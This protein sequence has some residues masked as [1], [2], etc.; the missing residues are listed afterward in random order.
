[1]DEPRPRPRLVRP[2][3]VA[4]APKKRPRQALAVD[5]TLAVPDVPFSWEG[6]LLSMYLATLLEADA[7]DDEPPPGA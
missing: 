3:D 2:T 5:G 6:T 7:G 1:V 4:P